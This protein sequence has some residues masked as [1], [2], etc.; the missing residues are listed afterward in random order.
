MY[1]AHVYFKELLPSNKKHAEISQFLL[2][3]IKTILRKKKG[4]TAFG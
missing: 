1:T 2:S 4:V 3:F